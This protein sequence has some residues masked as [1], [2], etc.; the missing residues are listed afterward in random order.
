MQMH[1][2]RKDETQI[3]SARILPNSL[4]CGRGAPTKTVKQ[5]FRIVYFFQPDGSVNFS[6]TG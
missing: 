4:L 6:R 3:V 5:L 1:N 2:E